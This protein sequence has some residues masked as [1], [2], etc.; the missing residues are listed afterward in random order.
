MWLGQ[1]WI[2]VLLETCALTFHLHVHVA[3]IVLDTCTCGLDSFGYMI[4]WI[5]L[6][7]YVVLD[8][9]VLLDIYVLLDTCTFGDMYIDISLTCTCGLDSFGYMYM[10]LG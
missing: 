4:F 7:I 3:W 2:H 8:L 6:D 1:F 10:W 5:L 9:H